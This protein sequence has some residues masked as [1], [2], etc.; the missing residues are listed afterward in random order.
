MLE[1]LKTLPQELNLSQVE[2]QIKN[3]PK[4]DFEKISQKFSVIV[5]TSMWEKSE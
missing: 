3:T 5:L 1:S 4:S 2:E